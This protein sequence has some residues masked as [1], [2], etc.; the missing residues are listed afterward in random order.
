MAA[1]LSERSKLQVDA[2]SARFAAPWPETGLAG[3]VQGVQRY[4]VERQE[5]K[6][7]RERER[8]RERGERKRESRNQL[9]DLGILGRCV[10]C[11]SKRV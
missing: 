3:Q 2:V 4:D 11:L 8:E 6:R 9:V 7:E 1:A 10:C 5:R